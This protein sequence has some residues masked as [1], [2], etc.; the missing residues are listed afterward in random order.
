M[1]SRLQRTTLQSVAPAD[2]GQADL[3][4]QLRCDGA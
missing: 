3:L 4:Q 2:G 1:I